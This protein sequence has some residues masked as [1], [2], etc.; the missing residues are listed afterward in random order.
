MFMIL[1]MALQIYFYSRPCGR[2]DCASFVLS[3]GGFRFLLTPL[4]EGRPAK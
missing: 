2:G 1:V 3:L 4:R